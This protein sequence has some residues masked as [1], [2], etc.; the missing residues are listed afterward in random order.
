ME[1]QKILNLSNDANDSKFVTRKQNY[2][3]ANEIT[4]N[5][6][7]LKSNLCDQNHAYTLVTGD[8]NVAAGPVTQVT[9]KICA[10]FT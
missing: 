10:P 9:F 2:A 3:A 6:E 4:H 1:R 7:I 8:I 5:T